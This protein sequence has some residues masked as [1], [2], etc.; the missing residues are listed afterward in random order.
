M[1]YLLVAVLTSLAWCWSAFG[2]HV[3]IYRK[4]NE[5]VQRRRSSEIGLSDE[6]E[7]DIAI[8]AIGLLV[9]LII[10]LG[11]IYAWIGWGIFQ[12]LDALA[13]SQER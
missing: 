4:S 6:D 1:E 10:I 13:I 11:V 8:A 3:I 9:T 2:L 12:W 5:Y 7:N